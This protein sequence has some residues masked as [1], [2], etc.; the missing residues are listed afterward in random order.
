M[1]EKLKKTQQTKVKKTNNNNKTK[2]KLSSYNNIKISKKK[3]ENKSDLVVEASSSVSSTFASIST[4]DLCEAACSHLS[5]Y[6]A[7][8]PDNYLTNYKKIADSSV[9]WY[10]TGI[11]VSRGKKRER[12]LH[13]QKCQE[14]NFNGDRI[15]FCQDCFYIGCWKNGHAR[16]HYKNTNHKFATD[17][18]RLYVYC[19]ECNNYIYDF[20]FEEIKKLADIRAAED[21][22]IEKEPNS[23]RARF[24]V[25][26]P[27]P[28]ESILINEGSTSFTCAGFRG[29]YNLGATC[30]MNAVL[31]TFMHN[32]IIKN[33]FMMDKH[34]SKLC[35]KT[36]CMC[37]EVD[38]LFQ[39]FHTKEKKPYPPCSFLYA[40]WNSSTEL[41]GYAEQDAHEFFMAAI[42]QMHLDS[43]DCNQKCDCIMHKAFAFWMR[44]RITCKECKK[45]KNIDEHMVEWQLHLKQRNLDKRKRNGLSKLKASQSSSSQD[46][47]GVIIARDDDDDKN[48]LYQCLNK[49]L[50]E[51]LLF[52]YQCEFCTER[53]IKNGIP[54]EDAAKPTEN[55]CTRTITAK[56]LP[57]VL[58]FVVDRFHRDNKKT[59]KNEA[60]LTF[61]EEI[62]MSG[63]TSIAQD[64]LING[65]SLDDVE[66][67]KYHLLSVVNHEGNLNTGHYT[68]YCKNRGQWFLFD[69]HTVRLASSSEVLASKRKARKFTNNDA[70][71]AQDMDVIFVFKDGA[72]LTRS[73]EASMARHQRNTPD[74]CEAY[75]S[76]KRPS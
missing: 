18:K 45:V 35:D 52:G 14:C 47:N 31:Q 46:S 75:R 42:N 67:F 56:K 59:V 15:H 22:S 6:K 25:Y 74:I 24:E 20:E 55:N 32:P 12:K 49:N 27:T 53:K 65:G 26:K 44:S 68:V 63:Y 72:N 28:E 3:V 7:E 30:F 41:A 9:T 5:L 23:K 64:I 43:R 73:E 38:N 51:E 40:M 13:P 29:L 1:S 10:R 8:N 16:S 57:P 71:N 76:I 34:N 48:E 17:V 50:S 70:V 21:E 58:A 60:E 37:C 2:T 19:F 39:E 11:E 4:S 66:P 62:D 54:P 61:Y 33:Y 69:D 36:C